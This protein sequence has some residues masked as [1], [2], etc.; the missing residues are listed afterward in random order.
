MADDR[1]DLEDL[2]VRYTCAVDS[3]A[4]EQELLELFTED[5]VL[6]GPFLGAFEGRDAIKRWARQ[7]MEMRKT[8]SMRHF[9]SNFR[10]DIRG[11]T[12]LV[13]A[14]LLE[15]M[16][17]MTPVPGRTQPTVE[18]VWSGDYD[19]HARKKDGRWLLTGRTVRADGAKSPD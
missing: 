10:Y 15:T 16:T 13:K 3:A 2:I 5:A 1:R 12:A 17:Y 8:L 9:V 18:L 6:R 4:S 7:T 19:F 11:E 14:Y